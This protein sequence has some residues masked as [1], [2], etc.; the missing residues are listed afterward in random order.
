M[1]F[2]IVLKPL[3]IMLL[4]LNLVGPNALQVGCIWGWFLWVGGLFLVCY[5]LLCQL[6]RCAC[7]FSRFRVI[8][9]SSGDGVFFIG[10]VKKSMFPLRT[11]EFS[12][13]ERQQLPLAKQL[14]LN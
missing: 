10:H 9:L 2:G 6:E 5:I 14:L 3:S 1:L 8:C 11:C 4:A 13:T 7:F 12:K